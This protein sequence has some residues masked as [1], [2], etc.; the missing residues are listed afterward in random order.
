[1]AARKIVEVRPFHIITVRKPN[2]RR[3]GSAATF[4]SMDPALLAKVISPLC[5]ADI[6]N[7]SCSIIG[8][9]NGTAP[10]ATRVK[11]P[12]RTES[13]KVGTRISVKSSTGFCVTRLC[14]T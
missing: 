10:T 3:I 1:M 12:P 2:R 7:P 14:R 5:N 6:P 9:R 8:S 11:P 13:P 4:I